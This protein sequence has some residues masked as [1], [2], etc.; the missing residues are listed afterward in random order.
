LIDEEEDILDI[1]DRLGVLKIQYEIKAKRNNS[2]NLTR[3]EN[4]LIKYIKKDLNLCYR[5]KNLSKLKY[6]YYEYFNK[7]CDD[8]DNIYH[9]LINELKNVNEKHY[10]LYNLIKLSYMHKKV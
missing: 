6:L 9:S 1:S 5:E 8:L 7:Q 10:N 4:N 2:N 3:Y